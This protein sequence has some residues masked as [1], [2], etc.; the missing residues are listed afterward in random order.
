[1]APGASAA[2]ARNIT[3]LVAHLLPQGEPVIDPT[4]EIQAA[5][6]VTHAGERLGAAR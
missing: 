5:V 3:A 2:Y 4:D 6:V 1:M